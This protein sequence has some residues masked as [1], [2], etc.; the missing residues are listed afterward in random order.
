LK[1]FFSFVLACAACGGAPATTRTP[2][3][4]VADAGSAT[5][6]TSNETPAA[7]IVHFDDLGMTFTVPPGFHVIGDAE[8]AARIGSSANAHLQADLRKRAD[9]KKGVPLLAL[10]KDE[11]NVTLSVVVV[12]ADALPMELAQHQQEVMSANLQG[13][14]IVSAPASVTQDGVPG[15]EMSTRYLIDQ[16]RA[17]SRMRLFVR[18]GVATLVTAVWKAEASKNDEAAALLDGLKF[19]PL[20]N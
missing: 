20:P 3:P 6:T 4:P 12:P 5:P 9:A 19:Q 14:E 8:L 16:K 11:L 17:A 10:S 15:A 1:S 2:E 18:N 7:S 13:F